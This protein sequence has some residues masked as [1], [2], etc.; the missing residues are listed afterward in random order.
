MELGREWWI[1]QRVREYREAGGETQQELADR[2]GYS[3]SYITQI[4][5]GAKAANSRKVLIALAEAFGLEGMHVLTTPP[6]KP[7]TRAE[8]AIRT[9][10]PRIRAALAG[11][12]DFRPHT[13]DELDEDVDRL[14][15]ARMTCNYASLAESLPPAVA[16]TF[17][18]T[19]RPGNPRAHKLFVRTA[20][21][22][23][24]ALKGLGYP[25]LATLFAEKARW[26]AACSEDPA[27]VGA[28]T[29][30]LAQ[31]SLAG[32]VQG[33][34]QRSMT[35]AED[36]ANALTGRAD[37][38][39]L[40]WRGLL[41]LHAGLSRASLGDMEGAAAHADTAEG[42]A[43]RLPRGVDPWH[44]EFGVPNALIWRVGMLVENGDAEH[45]PEV[46]RRIDRSKIR[47]PQ[48]LARLL[49][50]IGRG[51]YA[52]DQHEL[53]IAAF[54]AAYEVSADETASRSSVQEI[55]GHMLRTERRRVG[56]LSLRKLAVNIG[57]DP[58]ATPESEG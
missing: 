39:S 49:I 44:M 46:A 43:A 30:A 34:R 27:A 36:G 52:G 58:L 22:A 4:E 23:S 45:A 51:H 24:L 12:L 18:L 53:A 55:V 20:M 19:E 42:L 7:R 56:S 57:V 8:Q 3:R 10:L 41:H 54:Q 9:S 25:D 37:D 32:G 38:D 11:A 40:A 2:V 15:V 50:D 21:T 1:G 48:R 29:F 16:R 5:S 35:L 13:L 17:A 31:C 47:Y 14:M 26:S 28:A 6:G 33:L